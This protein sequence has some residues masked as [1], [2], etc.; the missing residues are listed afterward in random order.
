[1]TN[2][3]VD[4]LVVRA[5]RADGAAPL[6]GSRFFWRVAGV[7]GVSAYFGGGWFALFMTVVAGGVGFIAYLSGKEA[8]ARWRHDLARRAWHFIAQDAKAFR[9]DLAS[10]NSLKTLISRIYESDPRGNGFPLSQAVRLLDAYLRQQK[11]LARVGAHLHSLHQ[12]KEQLLLKLARLN[13]L[14][15]DSTSG[16]ERLE[17]LLKDIFAFEV[18][19]V[20]IQASC[21]RLEAIVIKVH[22]AAEVKNLHHEISQLSQSETSFA[23]EPQGDETFDIERQIGREIETFLQL[24]RETDEHLRDV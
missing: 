13:E 17:L 12:Q 8:D 15:E 22:R 23:P 6:T 16:R 5:Q 14:G 2:E 7:A 4:V 19:T 24:E 10:T 21:S 9:S 3:E 20:A 11:R 18:S 1:M